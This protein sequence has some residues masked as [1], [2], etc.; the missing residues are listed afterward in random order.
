M[1]R[2]RSVSASSIYDRFVISSYGCVVG[3]GVSVGFGVFVL[4]GDGV[5]VG[6]ISV[7]GTSVGVS[8]GE[9]VVGDGG[10]LV[11]VGKTLVV[12]GS[13]ALTKEISVIKIMILAKDFN[14]IVFLAGYQGMPH[15]YIWF[16]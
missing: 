2:D 6:G 10:T 11:A 8:V 5:A 15:R 3:V 16:S 13:H 4:E 14:I 9:A 1:E 7:G 12:A